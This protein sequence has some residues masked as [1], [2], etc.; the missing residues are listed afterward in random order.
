MSLKEEL[1][2]PSYP[3]TVASCTCLNLRKASRAISH[4]YDEILQ[5]TGLRG[6]QVSLLMTVAR[7][8]TSTM[9]QLADLLVTDLTTLSRNLKVL[10]RDGLVVAEPG[11]DRRVREIKLTAQGRAALEQALPLWRQAQAYIKEHLGLDQWRGLISHLVQVAELST[12]A[13]DRASSR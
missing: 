11:R 6:T 5:P 8:E 3:E 1:S 10:E 13:R 9:T 4:V 12:P 2:L 7:E